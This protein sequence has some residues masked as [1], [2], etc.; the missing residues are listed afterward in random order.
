MIEL[1]DTAICKMLLCLIVVTINA[2][3]ELT[4]L[5][6]GAV[7]TLLGRVILDCVAVEAKHRTG[8]LSSRQA[9]DL[10]HS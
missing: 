2:A 5:L 10:A 4:G 3:T 1:K 8:W 6:Q 9:A 7:L